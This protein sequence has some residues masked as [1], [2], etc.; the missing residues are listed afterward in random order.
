MLRQYSGLSRKAFG[1]LFRSKESTVYQWE[2]GF[3]IPRLAKLIN[4]SVHFGISMDCILCGR[5]ANDNM[6]E[7]HLCEP[8]DFPFA[9]GV[10]YVM[11]RYQALSAGGKER[12][13][14]YLDALS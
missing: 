5:A 11:K 4:I 6:L 2:Q 10:S 12:L 1:A 7:K 8:S 13:I 3:C 14:G 9:G